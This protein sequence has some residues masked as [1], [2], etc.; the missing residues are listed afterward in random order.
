MSKPKLYVSNAFSLSMLNRED[1]RGSPKGYTPRTEDAIMKHCRIPRP[2]DDPARALER[3]SQGRE[4]VSC[5]GHENTAA[6]LSDALGTNLSSQRTTVKLEDHDVLLVGQY[7]G[8]RLP[9]G[10]TTLP[11]GA[12]I[13]WWLV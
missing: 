1:Q 13:E 8:P 9:E 3:L 10:A 12:T 7:I 11:E 5:I 2:V 4:I 6:V